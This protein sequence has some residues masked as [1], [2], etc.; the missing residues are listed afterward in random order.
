MLEK[1]GQVV[2]GD[3]GWLIVH[4]KADAPEVA[5]V[6]ETVLVSAAATDGDLPSE[7]EAPSG[8][9]AD[10]P[11]DTNV[12]SGAAAAEPARTSL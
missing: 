3:S 8:V 9:A 4:R 12:P 10:L 11:S 7:T 5:V 2:W 6:P 1:H